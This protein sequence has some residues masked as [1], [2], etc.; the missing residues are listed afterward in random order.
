MNTAFPISTDSRGQESQQGRRNRQVEVGE[1]EVCTVLLPRLS[2]HLRVAWSV[3]A[4]TAKALTQ[5]GYLIVFVHLGS[6]EMAGQYALGLAITA[7]IFMFLNLGLRQL[8][9]TDT[10]REYVFGDYLGL[11]ILT[12]ILGVLLVSVVVVAMG[13]PRSTS[14]IILA[15][16]GC[17]SIEAIVDIFYGLFQ[18]QERHDFIAIS[19]GT[20]SVASLG[21]LALV[22]W[23]TSSVLHALTAAALA[24]LLLLLVFDLRWSS[25]F[26]DLKPRCSLEIIKPLGSIALPLGL[27]AMFISLSAN[28]PRYFL[29]HYQGDRILGIYA[30]LELFLQLVL[31]VT[32]S[33]Q[34]ATSARLA[35]SYSEGCEKFRRNL[36]LLLVAGVAWGGL[37]TL[38]AYTGGGWVLV[39]FF[40]AEFVPYQGD[41]TLLIATAIAFNL[42]CF[43]SAAMVI[44][45]RTRMQAT[46]AAVSTLAT[47]I[48]GWLIVPKFGITG[49]IFT[50]L[51]SGIAFVV[52]TIPLL[53]PNNLI[54]SYSKNAFTV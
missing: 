1:K 47:F 33:I 34:Q 36:S 7:P 25:S 18:Q 48:L 37:A 12:T 40:G 35:S 9:G 38:L 32:I 5:A 53:L 8:Q 6:L 4:N 2:L 50:M 54:K 14:L 24:R 27:V 31:M 21:A 45:R 3:L 17:R 13:C 28:A 39:T 23:V 49:A 46:V 10:N 41:F 52:F 30:M 44:M 26:A 42:R 15:V 19:Q 29:A 11:R 16:A 51:F 43:L 20:K 22:L